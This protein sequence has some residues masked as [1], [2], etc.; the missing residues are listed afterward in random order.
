[1]YIKLSFSEQIVHATDAWGGLVVTLV[2]EPTI[3]RSLPVNVVANTATNIKENMRKTT[4]TENE[5]IDDSITHDYDYYLDCSTASLPDIKKVLS[6]LKARYKDEKPA[7]VTLFS[8]ASINPI[9]LQLN[10][11]L[12]KLVK[13]P[14]KLFDVTRL[15]TEASVKKIK[16]MN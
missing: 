7:Q 16:K 2:Y 14:V 6:D 5:L 9:I 8:D 15:E 11:A 13:A 1:M 3:I 10:E 4:P 12:T